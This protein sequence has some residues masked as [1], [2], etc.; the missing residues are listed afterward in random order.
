[1]FEHMWHGTTLGVGQS[2]Q[3]T[4]YWYVY[5]TYCLSIALSPAETV[6]VLLL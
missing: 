1:M 4:S 5:N 3:T 6:E 2:K